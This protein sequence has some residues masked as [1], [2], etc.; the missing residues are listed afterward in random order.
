MDA[1]GDTVPHKVGHHSD[2]LMLKCI[3]RTLKNGIC[4]DAAQGEGAL[5][6][7]G[8]SASVAHHCP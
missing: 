5:Y 7:N 4:W 2:H 3:S 1:E 6:Q 8:A